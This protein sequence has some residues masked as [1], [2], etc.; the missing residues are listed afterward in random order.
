MLKTFITYFLVAV[1]AVFVLGKPMMTYAAK[2]KVG[3]MAYVLDSE[4]EDE[5]KKESSEEE[6]DVFIAHQFESG[7]TVQHF[8]SS[9]VKAYIDKY[10]YRNIITPFVKGFH[11]PPEA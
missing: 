9:E 1:I 7:I 3:A 11:I 8:H 2:C 5:T 6:G 10:I 4:K